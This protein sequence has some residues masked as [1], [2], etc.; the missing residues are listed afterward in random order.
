M[1]RTLYAADGTEVVTAVLAREAKSASAARALVRE[2]AEAWHIS[3]VAD[4]AQLVVTELVANA[5]QHARASLIRVT[6]RRLHEGGVRIAVTDKSHAQPVLKASG[7]DQLEGRGLALVDAVSRAWGVDP[8]PWGKRVWA[9]LDP[10]PEGLADRTSTQDVPM[11][12]TAA[13]QTVYVLAVT[14]L[15]VLLG[16]AVAAR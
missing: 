4:A 1:T 6:I 16:L 2:T 14:A 10:P 5:A 3:Q 7:P 15:A 8:L 13:A 11:F 9:D 12:A